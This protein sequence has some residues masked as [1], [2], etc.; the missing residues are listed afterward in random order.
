MSE[1]IGVDAIATLDPLIAAYPFKPYRNY[2]ALSRRRQDE[3]LRAELK[4]GLAAAGGF[5]VAASG[6]SSHAAGIVRPL[7]WDSGFFDIRMARLMLVHDG[8]ADRSAIHHVVAAALEACRDR[9]VRHVSVRV[10]LR[11]G[12]PFKLSKTPGSA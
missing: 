9:G 10:T 3:V 1:I 2:R 8:D 4:S 11:K 7:P 12:K 6:A 5:G